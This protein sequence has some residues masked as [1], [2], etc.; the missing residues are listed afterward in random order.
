[1]P[2]HET[3]VILREVSKCYTRGRAITKV[4]D[5]VSLTVHH[6]ECIFLV[7]PS[8]SGKTT[9]LS[10]IG[11][12]LDADSGDVC[13]LGHDV[14][15]LDKQTSAQLRRERIGFVF[16]RFHLIRGLTAM[17]N[18]CVPLTLSGCPAAKAARRA[19]ELLVRVGLQ[20]L[21]TAH[22]KRMS[23]GECQRVALARS[24]AADPDLILADEP[25]SSLDA[26]SGQQAMELLR[27]L[28]VGAGKSLIVV[29]HDH[30][31]LPFADRTL[32]I[33]S[34]RLIQ[35]SRQQQEDTPREMESPIVSMQQE[36]ASVTQSTSNSELA[37]LETTDSQSHAIAPDAVSVPR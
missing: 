29:T 36:S 3:A 20:D 37:S 7:G 12:V 9:L 34:G 22:P 10:I 35:A 25:T 16:Q 11:C 6:G 23:V 24:L 2:P 15:Q 14:H 5:S 32:S 31:I 8:G 18:V 21:R 1:M 4:L 19:T 17:E 33:E 13:I 26:E 27:E 30:R 28:T